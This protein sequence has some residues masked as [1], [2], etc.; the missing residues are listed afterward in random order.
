MVLH[1]S[2]LSHSFSPLFILVCE[3]IYTRGEI[4][5]IPVS[6]P[7]RV[8]RTRSRRANV[9]LMHR[10]RSW[11][12]LPLDGKSREKEQREKR[13]KENKAEEEEEEKKGAAWSFAWFHPSTVPVFEHFLREVRPENRATK[14]TKPGERERKL[15]S[16]AYVQ[17]YSD[18]R[19]TA[20]RWFALRESCS[21]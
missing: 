5:R 18:Y 21:S 3:Y 17:I 15:G 16:R 11:L 13:R 12:S 20:R 10:E 7:G 8:K 14:I 9:F 1:V 6:E 4:S 19:S 2:L